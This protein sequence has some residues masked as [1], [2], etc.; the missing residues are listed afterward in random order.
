MLK[1]ELSPRGIKGLSDIPERDRLAL[2]DNVRRFAQNPRDPD[3]AKKLTNR[4]EFTVRYGKWRA[5]VLPDFRSGKLVLVDAG[6][7][8]LIYG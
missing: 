7:R 2:M 1:L 4:P 6:H 3:R 5:L 8:R